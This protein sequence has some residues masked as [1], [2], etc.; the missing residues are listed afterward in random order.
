M[1]KNKL[2]TFY[3]IFISSLSTNQIV[4][5]PINAS[6]YIDASLQ[7][8]LE[9][10]F[11]AQDMPVLNGAAAFYSY[12]WWMG[13]NGFRFT[14]AP[15]YSFQQNIANTSITVSMV[16]TGNYSTGGPPPLH[17]TMAP[18][19]GSSQPISVF[20]NNENLLVQNYRNAVVGDFMY[21][22]VSY[23]APN[24]FNPG[25]AYSGTISVENPDNTT[26]VTSINGGANSFTPNQESYDGDVSWSFT[27]LVYGEERSILIP[28]EI[29]PNDDERLIFNVH[30]NFEES[31]T[32]ELI[33]GV[34]FVALETVVAESHDP[35]QLIAH[36]N[37]L[38][39]CDYGGK[40]INYTVHFQNEG[41]GATQY[42]KVVCLLDEKLDLSSIDNIEVPNVYNGAYQLKNSQNSVNG[43]QCDYFIDLDNHQ[44]I[45]E[46]YGLI[47]LSPTDTNCRN[48]NLT[49]EQVSFSINLLPNYRF[50]PKVISS[51]E[52][53]FDSNPIIETN[54]TLV[55]CQDPLSEENG[56]GFYEV[57]TSPIKTKFIIIGAIILLFVGVI[58]NQKVKK[59]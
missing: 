49:R 32:E 35:N 14:P 23:K 5:Q 47:L 19:T 15:Q 6:P 8:S 25:S 31:T 53:T 11:E 33:S 1:K 12:L 46:F 30:L 24:N 16:A 43:L 7:P 54:Q 28:I 58:V 22:I 50:G 37:A 27:D 4:G 57:N 51:A 10:S 40:L 29:L 20:S 44:V 48:L 18:K 38:N 41:E 21:L 59:K 56:G 55:G 52:I 45:F 3:L 26:I 9:Y 2:I 42:V 34:N 39:D 17:L 36:S 13:D